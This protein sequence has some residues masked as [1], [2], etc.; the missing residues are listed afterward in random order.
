MIKE[1]NIKVK[2]HSR[3]I[4]YYLSKG[5]DIKVGE[6]I[7]VKIEDLSKGTTFRITCSCDKCKSETTKE[8][9]E[10]YNYTK[11]L[12]EN[13]YCRKCKSVKSEKTNLIK[14]GVKNPMQ[15]D[16]VKDKLKKSLV[17][18]YGVTHYSKTEEYKMKFKETSI[19]NWGVDNPSKNENIIN[20]IKKKNTNRIKSKSFRKVSKTKKQRNTWKRYAERLPDSYECVGY[21]DSIFTI[22]H[23][24]CGEKFEITK[25][26]LYTRLK[27]TS[28]ICLE[29]NPVDIYKSSFENEVGSFLNTLGVNVEK[30][31]RK[32]L[33]GLELD[34]ILADFNIAIECNGVYWHN[35]LFKGNN[36]HINK[37][38]TCKEL[39]YELLH[40]W[41]D[42]WKFKKDIIKS[43]LKYRLG[44]VDKKIY[45]RKCILKEVNTKNYKEFLNNNHIQGYAS[46][47][48]NLGL[49]YNDELVSLMTFGWRRTNGK[50]EYELIR[51]CNKINTI[52]IG[53]AS[54][55]FKYF[56]SNYDYNQIISYADISLFNGNLYKTLGFK[57]SNLSKPNYHWVIDG[58]RK[59]RYNYSKRKL[60]KG[61]YNPNKTE[62][63]I[64]N[65]RGYYRVF[66]TGQEKYIFNN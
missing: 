12:T 64:M 2:G 63:E 17:E 1:K 52:V 42:D 30:G 34:Y 21:K 60:I 43:I 38:K 10:Y 59:H 65:E 23:N 61:G 9:R 57:F 22:K 48:I 53:S 36:Y 39:G 11:G 13:Y 3:N 50:K 37:T 14:Y 46:S 40:I 26:L 56:L 51:F 18:K 58:I 27:N 33:N 7:Y 24:D 31:N 8:F 16:K 47:S 49:Y 20:K 41:E 5:Y 28:I 55:L 32:L 62:V 19:K 15:N 66:S 29:C 54:K 25:A 35:E 44:I 6:V 4:K 45:A